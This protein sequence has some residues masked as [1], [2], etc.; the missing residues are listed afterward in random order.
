[1]QR[2]SRLVVRTT[3]IWLRQSRLAIDRFCD[4]S[5]FESL[6]GIHGR[7]YRAVNFGQNF[8]FSEVEV[9]TDSASETKIGSRKCVVFNTGE[10]CITLI[11]K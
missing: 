6:H 5:K 11:S 7:G 4:E 9:N 10:Q 8:Y 1:M 3:V 2:S